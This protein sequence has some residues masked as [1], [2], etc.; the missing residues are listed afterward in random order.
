MPRFVDL[1]SMKGVDVVVLNELKSA[2]VDEFGIKHLNI[3]YNLRL[4]NVWFKLRPWKQF[5]TLVTSSVS[6]DW[7]REVKRTN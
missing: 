5:E 4:T 6:S 1:H 2:P 3:L 7:I